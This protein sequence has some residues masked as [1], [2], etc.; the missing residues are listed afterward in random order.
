MKAAAP[1]T[2]WQ[3]RNNAAQRRDATGIPPGCTSG[4]GG[5]PDIK[6]TSMQKNK[7]YTFRSIQQLS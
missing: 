1:I 7:F 3:S 6:S 5:G 2:G 4:K